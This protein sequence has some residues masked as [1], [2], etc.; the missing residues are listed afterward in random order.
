MIRAKSSN[1]RI[2]AKAL[3]WRVVSVVMTIGIVFIVSGNI[4]G[5]ISIGVVDFFLKFFMY[6]GHEKLW[7]M[8]TW[9]KSYIETED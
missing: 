4:A 7:K 9:G 2:M 6:F 1:K 5:A 8:T 3:T